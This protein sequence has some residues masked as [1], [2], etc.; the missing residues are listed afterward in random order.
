MNIIIKS[1]SLKYAPLDLPL[2]VKAAYGFLWFSF[3]LGHVYDHMRKRS[4]PA[5]LANLLIDVDLE[6]VILLPSV[7]PLFF[8]SFVVHVVA[9]LILMILSFPLHRSVNVLGRKRWGEVNKLAKSPTSTLEA[10][11]KAWNRLRG[12]TVEAE[13]MIE[14]QAP[15][16]SY[17]LTVLTGVTVPFVFIFPWTFLILPAMGFVWGLAHLSGTY[18]IENG[19]IKPVN[20]KSG[21]VWL[22]SLAKAA[23]GI[24][25]IWF[26]AKSLGSLLTNNPLAE[27]VGRFVVWDVITGVLFSALYGIIPKSFHAL[28]NRRLLKKVNQPVAPLQYTVSRVVDDLTASIDQGQTVVFC[29]A[30]ISF[31][32]GLPTVNPFAQYLLEK[33]NL[34]L[35]HM[36]TIMGPQLD[37][38]GI[39]FEAFIESL[40]RNSDTTHLIDIYKAGKPNANHRLLAKLMKAGKYKT[41]VTTNF[42]TLIEDALKDEGWE[43]GTDYEVIY[44]EEDFDDIRWDDGKP[45]LIKIHGSVEEPARMAIT[46]RQVANQE[47]SASRMSVIKHVFG[48]GAH[49]N[50]LIL[51]Y[52]SS[53]VFDLCPQIEAVRGERKNIFYVRHSSERKVEPVRDE[54]TKNPFKKFHGQRIYYSTRELIE[55]IWKALLPEESY[56]YEIHKTPWQQNVD[57]WYE[58]LSGSPRKLGLPGHIF[59]SLSEYRLA[60][61]YYKKALQMARGI[62]DKWSEGTWL[63]NLGVAYEKLGDYQEAIDY[64]TQAIQIAQDFGDETV[65]HFWSGNLGNVYRA[66]GSYPEAI[67]LLENSLR[68]ARKMGDK[69]DEGARLGSLGTAYRNL[70]DYPMSMECFENALR[71]ARK[72]GDKSGESN[73]LL[74]IGNVHVDRREYQKASVYYSQALQIFQEIGDKKCEGVCLGNLGGVHHH[75]GNSLETIRYLKL[76]LRFS[77]YI[78]D[79]SSEVAWL[80][81]LGSAYGEL[82]NYTSQMLNYNEARRLARKIKDKKSECICLG[83]LG[84]VYFELKWKLK[85]IKNYRQALKIARKMD[86]KSFESKWLGGIGNVYDSLGDGRKAM[87]YYNWALRIAREIE[88]KENEGLALGALGFMYHKHGEYL[89]AIS[90]FRQSL[91]VIKP[92]LGEDNPNTRRIERGLMLAM[93]EMRSNSEGPDTSAVSNWRPIR[94]GVLFLGLGIA[95]ASMHAGLILSLGW[96][97]T[98]ALAGGSFMISALALTGRVQLPPKAYVALTSL[99]VFPNFIRSCLMFYQ[100]WWISREKRA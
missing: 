42:D 98:I 71:I 18:V 5:S 89:K 25:W 4:P 48:S 79:K 87:E 9:Y 44:K 10:L 29:G 75:L 23:V 59:D 86:Y 57:T 37:N 12:R 92:F 84:D 3:A 45:R 97:P 38:L 85:A 13:E 96:I 20:W 78:G 14:R 49:K 32:S 17:W 31:D 61:K 41:M 54:E 94:D 43:K 22:S 36:K 76:A 58:K 40:T 47:L 15:W 65:E 77:Y 55:K 46:L 19:E 50:V 66:R 83:K 80:I 81:N 28:A 100:A 56:T 95:T 93:E 73:A 63:G 82:K 68:I 1:A 6:I 2:L 35:N 64:Y 16:E 7:L 11:W 74:N 33:F 21:K 88:N 72:I 99:L 70:E 24:G 90:Y 53:D 69:R 8:P 91:D 27:Y 34:P 30:G 62:V 52:S 51:G 67:E 39:P 60:I 26:Y